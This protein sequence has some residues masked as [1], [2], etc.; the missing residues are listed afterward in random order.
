METLNEY[1]TTAQIVDWAKAS[2]NIIKL[3]SDMTDEDIRRIMRWIGAGLVHRVSPY[4][5]GLGFELF[6]GDAVVA[7]ERVGLAENLPVVGTICY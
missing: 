1:Q 5:G 4:L 7:D 2:L 6:S 3:N